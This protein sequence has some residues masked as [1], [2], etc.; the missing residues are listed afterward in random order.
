MGVEVFHRFPEVRFTK[1]FDQYHA[2]LFQVLANNGSVFNSFMQSFQCLFLPYL[3]NDG[4]R[5]AG[6][7]G[8]SISALLDLEE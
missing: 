3:V 6:F 2:S 7:G 1:D 8:V 4:Q 5:F